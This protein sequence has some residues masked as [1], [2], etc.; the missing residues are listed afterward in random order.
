LALP[1]SSTAEAL[2]SSSSSRISSSSSLPL[3]HQNAESPYKGQP[4]SQALKLIEDKDEEDKEDMMALRLGR[5][6]G[7]QS[8]KNRKDIGPQ[9]EKTVRNA[10]VTPRTCMSCSGPYNQYTFSTY[11]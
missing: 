6:Q 1:E 8:F 5:T 4:T 7:T 9:K 2:S 10:K 11:H 3:K